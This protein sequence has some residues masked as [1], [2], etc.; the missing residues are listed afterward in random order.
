M[1]K[2]LVNTIVARL[3]ALEAKVLGRPRERLTKTDLA[4]E[5]GVSTRSVDRRVKEGKLPPPDD[6]ING[7]LYWW[8][9]S[10][11]RHRQTRDTADTAEAR[12]LR[13]PRRHL[14]KPMHPHPE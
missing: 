2:L 3:D 5:E 8:S 1:G 9:D 12:A 11:E 14:R 4:K 7:R 6:V 13:N 10:I